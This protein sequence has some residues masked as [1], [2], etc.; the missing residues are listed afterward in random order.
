M[1]SDNNNL[2]DDYEVELKANEEIFKYGSVKKLPILLKGHVDL[3]QDYTFTS[4]KLSK[5]GKYLT[6]IGRSKNEKDPDILYI[7]NAKYLNKKRILELKGI[8][9]IEVVDFAPDENTFVIVYK[10]KPPVFFDFNK[11][12]EI[13]KCQ[14]KSIKHTKIFAY[15]FSNKGKNFAI[16]SD[17]DFVAYNVKTGKIKRQIISDAPIKVFRGKRAVF[18]DENYKVSVIDVKEGKTIKEFKA[19]AMGE[20]DDILSTMMAPDK[21]YIYYLKK[22]GV[23]KINIDNEDIMQEK[24]E[25]N[26]ILDGLISEDC[27]ICMTTDKTNAKFWDL[28]NFK[29]IGD[30]YKEKFDSFSVNFQ[31]SKLITCDKICI[32]LTDIMN[33]K[34][35]QK[36]IWLDLNPDKFQSFSF[37]PD[38]KVILAKIDEHTAISYNCKSG[39]V[40]RK[41]KIFLPNWSRACEMVPETS[42]LGVIAT[43]SYNK[44]IKIWDYLTGT[45]LSTFTGFDVNNFSFS[46][47]GT[48]LSAGTIEGNEIARVWDLTNGDEFSYMYNESKNNNKNTFVNISKGEPL[49]VIAVA[50]EQNPIIF[51][52]KEKQF[53]LECTGCPI[54][55]SSISNV[56]SNEG[57]KY[58][59]IYGKDINNILTAILYDFNGQLIN[60]YNNCRNIEF[61]KEDK[62]LLSD[63][64]NINKG[65]LTISNISDPNNLTEIECDI[66]GVNSKFLQDN[67]TIATL[68]NTDDE[69]KKL[70]SIKNIETGDTI[71]EIEY[72]K[73]TIKYTEILITAEKKENN[74]LFRFI[75]LRNP[76]KK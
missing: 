65:C 49:R 66:S 68:L 12:E 11:G 17:K 63:S 6:A 7:W 37:S 55:L 59:F 32:D 20:F 23:Y 29:S 4:P 58:F 43:K 33:D 69:N 72:I 15:S 19:T 35:E 41:W 70:I 76:D 2:E 31:Q 38:Y 54:Q 16:A 9:K 18:I 1:S 53:I 27:K 46:K 28:E 21:S 52:L 64:D 8:S 14:D 67:K 57:N 51:D 34:A 3:P 61:G 30:I 40:I 13:S 10:D 48:Y 50:E 71:A 73:K 22:D 56:K 5:E 44:I 62:Y 42:S 47:D 26:P 75:E 25:K 45:D 39:E 74:L 24:M 36:F 60:E